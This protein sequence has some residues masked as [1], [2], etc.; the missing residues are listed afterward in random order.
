MVF[1]ARSNRARVP[2]D[3]QRVGTTMPEGE[4]YT[5][6]EALRRAKGDWEVQL[7]NLYVQGGASDRWQA[8]PDAYAVCRQDLPRDDTRRVLSVVGSKYA[9]I[10]NAE[11]LAPCDALRA[12]GAR[13]ETVGVVR[14]GRTV[15]ACLRLPDSIRIHGNGSTDEVAPYL[16]VFT[17]H[18]GSQACTIVTS[19][20]RV[21]CINQLGAVMRSARNKWS[22]K[23][24]CGG[25]FRLES[26][27]QLLHEARDYFRKSGER[28]QRFAETSVSDLFVGAYLAAMFPSGTG[29][30][31]REKATKQTL[32]ARRRVW[33]LFESEQ[34]GAEHPALKG[35]AY[36]LLNAMT[37][38]L[39]Y[40]KPTRVSEGRQ[41]VEARLDSNWFGQGARRREKA[42]E[43]LEHCAIGA[44]G[45]E[46]L[47]ER[48]ERIADER[49]APEAPSAL[50]ELLAQ[51][52]LGD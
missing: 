17:S 32:K 15:F 31:G 49:R 6:A 29:A 40:E 24:T 50:E 33:E 27:K 47:V 13:I 19:P 26:A 7:E 25:R 41:L 10:Q 21:G 34:P 35:T 8:V 12:E 45:K 28:L 37:R 16:N 14:G 30:N 43:L 4:N 52:D 9:A 18:D 5:I 1:D 42:V 20:I 3:W 39:E 51:I 2:A 23:H 36:G 22:Y 48:A 46:T 44:D 11:A 38:F